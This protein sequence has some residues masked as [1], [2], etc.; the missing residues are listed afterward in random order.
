MKQCNSVALSLHDAAAET[1]GEQLGA[2]ATIKYKMTTGTV[3]QQA[4]AETPECSLIS[5]ELTTILYALEHAGDTLRKTAYV[6]VATKSKEAL[7]GIEKWQ[8]VGYGRE[9]V[10]NFADAVLEM[11]SV[12]HRVTVFL[13]PWYGGIRGVAEAKQAARAVTDGA[14]ELTAA[15]AKRVHKLSGVLRLVKAERPKSLHTH[16]DDTCVEYH[17]WK[18]DEP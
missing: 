18:V 4:I 2:A 10:P 12:G 11:K 7:S 14:S 8:R 13:V 17:T 5:A 9:V 15:P 6:Y 16:E 1:E 3:K